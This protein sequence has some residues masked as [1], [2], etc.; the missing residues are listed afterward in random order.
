MFFV[1]MT[2]VSYC[3]ESY[4]PQEN[5]YLDHGFRFKLWLHPCRSW[6]FR[7]LH[8]LLWPD[9]AVASTMFMALWCSFYCDLQSHCNCALYA[10]G[11]STILIHDWDI[12]NHPC[13]NMMKEE[14]NLSY[15]GQKKFGISNL[16]TRILCHTT[17]SRTM[18]PL[19]LVET[20][21]SFAMDVH[22]I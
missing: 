20:P 1:M 13:F 4:V 10:S 17:A 8:N 6:V 9:E 22:F 3:C 12:D 19:L 14:W 21:A 18:S 15:I 16:S 2:K 11:M 5:K 7:A